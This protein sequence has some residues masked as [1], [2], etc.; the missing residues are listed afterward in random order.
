M[1]L[2]TIAYHNEIYNLDYMLA[3]E[4]SELLN[5]L[6]ENQTLENLILSA[7]LRSVCMNKISNE[8]ICQKVNYQ[9]NSLKVS[10]LNINPKFCEK[11]KYYD[12]VKNEIFEDLENFEEVL[13]QLSDRFDEKI[14]E[15]I[16]EELEL[17]LQIWRMTKKE[18]ERKEE[19]T[20]FKKSK[21]N[22]NL[23]YDVDLRKSLKEIKE[24]KRGLISQ[25]ENEIFSA[26]EVGDKA[27]AV[28]VKK[29]R[30]IKNV[31]KLLNFKFNTYK[32][33]QKNI[34]EPFKR[35]IDEFKVNELG[36]IDGKSKEFDLV[37]VE[38][39]INEIAENNGEK[40]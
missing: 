6:E 14:Q 25:K 1:E 20:F 28:G 38:K 23:R 12:K 27:L 8:L 4:I 3:V 31:A 39:K 26:M 37:S 7:K 40:N 34:L 35:R 21:K 33:I 24:K 19:K 32:V 22:E 29:R 18:N 2:G 17:E 11:V 16:Y 9:M 15:L 36:K 30:K 10:I 5:L 13:R